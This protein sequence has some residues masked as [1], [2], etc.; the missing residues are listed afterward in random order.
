[1]KERLSYQ[2][3]ENN[4]MI[5]CFKEE[6]LIYNLRLNIHFIKQKQKLLRPC[7]KTRKVVNL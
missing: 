4:L 5:G 2:F 6:Q 7:L 3:K 1:M